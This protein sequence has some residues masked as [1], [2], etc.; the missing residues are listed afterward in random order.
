MFGG[1]WGRYDYD[2]LVGVYGRG[3]PFILY[4]NFSVTIFIITVTFNFS[5]LLNQLAP[6]INQCNLCDHLHCLHA[7]AINS[8]NVFG[9]SIN[10]YNQVKSTKLT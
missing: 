9:N 2:R 3:V 10:L 4:L 7:H 5:T 8:F 6:Q 1:R